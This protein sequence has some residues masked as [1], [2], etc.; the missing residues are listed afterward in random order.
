MNDLKLYMKLSSLPGDIKSE[1]MDY[2]DFLINKKVKKAPFIHPKAGCMK[3][4]F[5]MD[6]DFDEPLEDFKEYME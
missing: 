3:G 2:V 4:T 5:T 1:I 6:P